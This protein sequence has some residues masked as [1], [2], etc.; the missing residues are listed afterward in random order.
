[1]Y[2]SRLCLQNYRCYDNFEIDFN[3]ELTVIVAE[4]G[5]GKTAILDAVAVALGPYLSVL[6]CL[7]N[8]LGLL[9]MEFC[10][11][12]GMRNSLTL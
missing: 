6:S 12:Y 7:C 9:L 3:K 5:K 10:I 2:I 4:N 11:Q 1:M 8:D